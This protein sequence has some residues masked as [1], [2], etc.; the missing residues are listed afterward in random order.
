VKVVVSASLSSDYDK[1][2]VV[3]DEASGEV[4]D[5]AQGY[6]YKSAQNAHQAYSY[7]SMPTKEKRQREAVDRAGGPCPGDGHPGH[8]HVEQP[9]AHDTEHR[10]TAHTT[11]R[12][13][14]YWHYQLASARP[15]REPLT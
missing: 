4:L 14:V 6:G 9:D 15:R 1:R 10:G 8:E 5:D 11:R 2:Y 3:V 7:K 13:Y 12:T